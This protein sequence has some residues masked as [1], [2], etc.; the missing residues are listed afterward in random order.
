MYEL[1][2]PNSLPKN[3]GTAYTRVRLFHAQIWYVFRVNVQW[4]L[5]FCYADPHKQKKSPVLVLFQARGMEIQR[6]C[7]VCCALTD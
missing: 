1:L 5:I 4:L 2:F 3:L 7:N 6:Y